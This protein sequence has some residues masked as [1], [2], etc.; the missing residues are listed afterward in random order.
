MHPQMP[1]VKRD[2]RSPGARTPSEGG[3][4][5][6]GFHR[7]YHPSEPEISRASLSDEIEDRFGITGSMT[8][9][10]GILKRLRG[11]YQPLC[12]SLNRDELGFIDTL[13]DNE[14]MIGYMIMVGAPVT[15]GTVWN[16]LTT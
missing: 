14:H 13:N 9:V 2:F 8:L 6:G 11:K 15:I 5:K 10:N 16:I 7:T 4:G 1:S 12:H 3:I